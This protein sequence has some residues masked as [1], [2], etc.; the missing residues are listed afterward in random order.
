MANDQQLDA[1]PEVRGVPTSIAAFVGRAWRGPIDEPI[2]I[3]SWSEYERTFGGL[4][5]PS[6]MGF[7]VQQFFTNGGE[8]AVVVRV[9]TRTGERRATAASMSVGDWTF[10]AAD[11]GSWGRNLIVTFDASPVIAAAPP[12]SQRNL[13]DVTIVDDAAGT[14]DDDSRGGTGATERFPSVSSDPA[15]TRFVPAVL[16]EESFLLRVTSVGADRPPAGSISP[17]ADSGSDGLAID[18]ADVSDAA[19]DGPNTGIYALRRTDLFNILCIPP[20]TPE[21]IDNG[22]PTWAAAAALCGERRAMLLVDAPADWSLSNPSTAAFGAIERANAAIYFPRLQ[23]PDP[24]RRDAVADFA[25]SGAVAGLVARTDIERGVW[26]APAGIDAVLRGVVGLSIDGA[27]GLISDE[28]S[29]AFNEAGINCLRTFP[30]A[31]TVAWGARTMEGAEGPVSDWKYVPV[32]RLAIYLEES[33]DRG[34]KWVV[35]EPNGE[36]LWAR[37]RLCIG[38]FLHELFGLGAFQGATPSEAWF[39]KCDS[40]TTTARDVELGVV[41]I[42]IGFAPLKPAEFVLIRI[43]QLAGQTND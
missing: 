15:S 4:W 28:D 25:P 35:F 27:P 6:T 42:V 8:Q 30:N 16:A 5:R 2:A 14:A 43:Q 37:I 20:F 7:A 38:A 31:G 1:V 13:F 10:E 19:N 21:T 32:R 22:M 40:E 17:A 34:T 3:G 11:P 41:N 33:I 18:A 23:M 29:N 24:L 12:A 9:A 26:K 36:P 39:V